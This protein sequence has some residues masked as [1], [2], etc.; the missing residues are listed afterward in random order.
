[1]W[2]YQKATCIIRFEQ[3][4]ISMCFSH[5]LTKKNDHVSNKSV[6]SIET[7]LSTMHIV[8]PN[9]SEEI[10]N[11]AVLPCH[12]Q[13]QH[14]LDKVQTNWKIE[15]K[16][17]NKYFELKFYS[18]MYENLIH[19]LHVEICNKLLQTVYSFLPNKIEFK[20]NHKNFQINCECIENCIGS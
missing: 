19:A 15:F 1:M 4:S 12:I 14:S 8:K 6:W 20:K 17:A 10:L 11:W 3:K 13:I 7:S 9:E 18:P 2:V 5:S 16:R